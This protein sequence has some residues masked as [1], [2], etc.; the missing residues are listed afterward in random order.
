MQRY[1]DFLDRY[2]YIILVLTTLMVALFS[3]A[4]KDLAYEGSYKIWF[5]KE[6]KILKDY[7]HFRTTFS[8]DDTF[9]VAF[10]DENGIFNQKAVTTILALTDAFK[11]IDGVR[12]VNSLT[13]YQYISSQDDEIIVED[14]IKDFNNLEKKRVFAVNDKLILNQLIDKEGLSTAIAVQLSNE[15]GAN[16]EVNIYVMRAI[17]DITDALSKK[18]GYK[19][20]ITGAPAITASLVTISQSDAMVLMPLAV[21]MVMALLFTLFRTYLG[22]LVPSI[23]IVFTFLLV[24]SIQVLLGY[25][26]NNFTVNIPSF[27]TAIAIADAMHLYLAWVFYRSKN[28]NNKEALITAFQNNIKPV[29]LTSFTTASGFASLGLSAIEPIATLGIAITA[30]AVIAFVLTVTLIPVLLLIF[31]EK[32]KVKP[33]KFLN[34]FHTKGYGAFI[35]KHDKKIVYSFGFLFL[36]FAYGL[37]FIKVDSNSIKYFSVDTA[38][39]SG[40]DFI[41][42]NLTGSMVYEIVL[43]SKQKEGVKNSEFL[44]TVV[45]FE[46][47]LRAEYKNIRFT[48]SLKDIVVRMQ[49][50]LDEKSLHAIPQDK[51]LVA[52]YLLLYSMSLP[53]GM[54][55]NDKIDTSEQFLRLSINT[56]LV[57]TSKDLEMIAW[58][59]KWWE[60]NSSFSADVQ[61]QTAIFAYM[62]S[63]LTNTLVLSI[64]TTLFTIAPFMYLIFRNFKILL[65][66]IVPNIAPIIFVS[67][68]MGYLNINIDLGIA[69]SASIILGIAVDD[70]IH[71]FSKFFDAIKIK[72]F[73]DSIDYVISHSG[74]AMILTTFILSFTFALFGLSSFIPNVNFAIVTVVALN[75]AVLFDLV[76]LPA[77]LSVFYEKIKY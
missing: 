8:G 52:Q 59:K 58:I 43:D 36:F 10:K 27:V 21:I 66:F 28:I 63:S 57:N 7:E 60:T 65:I 22:V 34:L 12:K 73:E 45:R 20:Y 64:T 29:A 51:N 6:S 72:T 77:L 46:N 41:E 67:G 75:M 11:Q 61:G 54:E 17:Q 50:V 24:L 3:I 5:D 74:N 15:S 69:I 25:K 70:T 68:V 16:E 31:G 35:V 39:R 13:N 44:N 30:A 62:Q 49:E 38:V 48:T 55:I 53:Q 71:F 14:F 33:L 18:S 4:L 1:I 42:K 32:H 2:K 47:D 9:I 23:V 26:L 37:S 19:F 40:S 56:N 76:L